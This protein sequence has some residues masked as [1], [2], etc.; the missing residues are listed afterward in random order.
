MGIL[1]VFVAEWP[2]NQF[3]NLGFEEAF[4]RVFSGEGGVLRFWR[5]D[6]VVVI[7]RHQCA[8]LEVNPD[9]LRD[10]GVKLVRRFTGGG[11]VYHDLGNINYALVVKQ[12]VAGAR[13]VVDLFH[14]VGEAVADALSSLG[15]NNA[16]YRAL[17]DVEI[18]GRKVSGL[19]GTSAPG[20]LFV[21]GA[22]LVSSDLA[23]LGRVL[24]ISKEKLSDKRFVGSRVKRVIT[25]E[26]AVGRKLEPREVYSAIAD[27]L[28]EKLG[29][30][31]EWGE[32][33]RE[34]LREA[35][36]LYREKYSRPA[37][38]LKY[39]GFVKDSLSGDEAEAL[40]WAA[41]PDPEQEKVA[42]EVKEVL[43]GR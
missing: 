3:F 2:R 18:D 35:L 29:L 16:Y 12:G 26:E 8:A 31:K 38:N 11:A 9:A 4:Y 6:R 21:H 24:R 5:N 25:L 13:T 40:M 41:Q 14:L 42:E 23:I 15:A 33:S 17:N 1:R 39:L 34:E 28:A 36:R 32:A 19:A 20:K 27:A 30:E 37:W 43:G 22:L 7:G 10:M